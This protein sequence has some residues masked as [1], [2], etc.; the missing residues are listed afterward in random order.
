MKGIPLCVRDQITTQLT[1][2]AMKGSTRVPF[3]CIDTCKYIQIVPRGRICKTY[4]ALYDSGEGLPIMPFGNRLQTFH[5]M[6]RKKH[7]RNARCSRVRAPTPSPQ[8]SHNSRNQT[9]TGDVTH[10]LIFR[11]R[12]RY[13]TKRQRPGPASLKKDALRIHCRTTLSPFPLHLFVVNRFVIL[14]TAWAK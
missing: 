14:R 5:R 3:K 12:K 4:V 9:I 13:T 1:L 7:A 11:S 2:W 10:D 6:I 8:L